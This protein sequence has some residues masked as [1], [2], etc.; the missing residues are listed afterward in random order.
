MRKPRPVE[1]PFDDAKNL[2]LVL[3]VFKIFAVENSVAIPLETGA[4]IIL[5]R[6]VE[7]PADGVGALHGIIRQL[8]A[9][10]F[11][12]PLAGLHIASFFGLWPLDGKT[13]I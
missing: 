11:L 6:A 13:Q 7:R 5:L 1:I 3:E 2:S 10:P 4:V 8:L 12:K 9:F